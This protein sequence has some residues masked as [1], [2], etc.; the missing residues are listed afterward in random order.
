MIYEIFT[1]KSYINTYRAYT[2]TDH[3]YIHTYM[4]T[5]RLYIHMYI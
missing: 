2:H 5:F 4:H 3:T 1:C